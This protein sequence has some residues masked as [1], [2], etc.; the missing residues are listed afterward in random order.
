MHWISATWSGRKVTRIVSVRWCMVPNDLVPQGSHHDHRDHLWC[1]TGE[2]RRV[3]TR[4]P[5]RPRAT[6]A[7]TV[8]PSIVHS[9]WR[10]RRISGID[11]R[12]ASISDVA[13]FHPNQPWDD[14]LTRRSGAASTQRSVVRMSRDWPYGSVTR[15]PVTERW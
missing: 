13:S 7:R 15:I 1:R 5:R 8:S 2:L 12:M 11:H 14:A 9:R 4:I 6:L 10:S 3:S